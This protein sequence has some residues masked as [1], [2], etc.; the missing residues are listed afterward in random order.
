MG[1]LSEIP[2]LRAV[3]AERTQRLRDEKAGVSDAAAA[4]MGLVTPD[5]FNKR[6]PYTEDEVFRDLVE[7]VQR[8]EEI[9]QAKHDLDEKS[10][11]RRCPWAARSA[12]IPTPVGLFCVVAY[13]D[14]IKAPNDELMRSTV[15]A[16]LLEG[17]SHLIPTNTSPDVRI[18]DTGSFD[19][20]VSR[21]RSG[22][23]E[24]RGAMTHPPSMSNG[25]PLVPVQPSA[26]ALIDDIHNDIDG[27][28]AENERLSLQVAELQA[29][30][31]RRTT[32]FNPASCRE[33]PW[34][35]Q[36]EL[37]K[38][39]ITMGKSLSDAGL[40]H[41]YEGYPLTYVIENVVKDLGVAV[42]RLSGIPASAEP[43]ECAAL[44][45][46][47]AVKVEP[48]MLLAIRE[49]PPGGPVPASALKRMA[50]ALLSELTKRLGSMTY[51]AP[52]VLCI[53]HGA[54]LEAV[55]TNG[56]GP[57]Q[58]NVHPEGHPKKP[59]DVP[60]HV[61]R[62]YAEAAAASYGVTPEI[63]QAKRKARRERSTVV[64]VPAGWRPSAPESPFITPE[65]RNEHRTIGRDIIAYD[66][67]AD[68]M[69]ADVPDAEG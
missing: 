29:D 46:L 3:L 52:T 36:E 10:I 53:P 45:G 44:L 33:E 43:A 48:G 28:L 38:I 62:A 24:H 9:G 5:E 31:R 27:L 63:V 60:K 18:T 16:I 68:L 64:T 21:I 1:K 12:V 39:S 2:R 50:T 56:R 40:V 13:A 25:V 47:K 41:R 65:I 17:Y 19:S 37:H 20:L 35:A 8:R 32:R 42:A 67:P 14:T 26:E 61:A 34:D 30:I 59:T 4:R 7:K 15:R 6:A 58:V 23:I 11:I 51:G 49:P 22:L 54:T 55:P 57:V 69:C 66:D